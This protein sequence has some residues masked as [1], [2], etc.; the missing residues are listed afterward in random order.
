MIQTVSSLKSVLSKQERHRVD[1]MHR[2]Y[3]ERGNDY[4]FYFMFTFFFILPILHLDI[5]AHISKET[6]D[7]T[8]HFVNPVT[9]FGLYFDFKYSPEQ[10]EVL[11]KG[12]VLSNGNLHH[13]KSTCKNHCDGERQFSESQF[14]LCFPCRKLDG[15]WRKQGRRV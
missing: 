5:F 3:Q 15:T 7:V 2:G 1:R 14:P 4:V 10:R 9:H 8:V 6:S 11:S 13:T 12:V